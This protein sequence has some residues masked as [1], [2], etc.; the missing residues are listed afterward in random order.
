MLQS[1][2]MVKRVTSY[3][4]GQKAKGTL[5]TLGTN[6]DTLAVLMRADKKAI[7]DG[8]VFDSL[9]HSYPVVRVK[10]EQLAADA[11]RTMD[12][13]EWDKA[14]AAFQLRRAYDDH[15]DLAARN[16]VVKL[17]GLNPAHLSPKIRY[18]ESAS[19]VAGAE[20]TLR[21]T[22]ARFVL[23]LNIARVG[24]GERLEPGL[25]CAGLDTALYVRGAL[26]DL[27][28]CP[29]CDT[30]FLP[31]RPDQTYCSLRCRETHRKRRQ[32]SKSAKGE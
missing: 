18:D 10:D 3:I 28:A 17:H 32:R 15:D 31:E 23:W 8:F 19:I 5:E 12:A 30:P 14:I 11:K 2:S 7:A 29:C 16:A 13:R 4:P 27:R 20:F 21:M 1:R 26:R 9:Q 22:Q 6:R 24:R 25:L